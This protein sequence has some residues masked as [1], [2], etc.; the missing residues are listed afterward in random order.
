MRTYFDD[1]LHAISDLPT[2]FSA[3]QKCFTAVGPRL[4]S[5]TKTLATLSAVY[6]LPAHKKS[7]EITYF[8]YSQSIISMMCGG[9]S[10]NKSS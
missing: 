3:S 5:W 4:W 7:A 6:S 10:V 1:S 9:S 8:E 2:Y